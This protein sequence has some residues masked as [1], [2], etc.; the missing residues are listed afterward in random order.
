LMSVSDALAAKVERACLDQV[1]AWVLAGS[2]G[3][4]FDAVVLRAETNSGEVFVTEPP[5]MAKCSGSELPEG[6][7]ITVRLVEADTTRRKVS[8]ERYSKEVDRD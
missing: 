3:D 6:E 1:E 5:V 2:V 4:V 8:F 7:R